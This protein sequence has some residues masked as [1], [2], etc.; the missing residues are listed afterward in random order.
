MRSVLRQSMR[1]L[2]TVALFSSGLLAAG[3]PVLAQ[4][5]QKQDDNPPYYNW[6]GFY[7]GANLGGAWGSSDILSIIPSG[8][9]F[10]EGELYQGFNN[11][12]LPGILAAYRSNTLDVRSL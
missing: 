1:V 4:Q 6:N 7:A 2:A 11:P 3:Q 9:P 5:K 8:V 12:A 10:F